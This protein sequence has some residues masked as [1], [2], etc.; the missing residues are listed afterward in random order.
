MLPQ[1][2]ETAKYE[3]QRQQ[4]TGYDVLTHNIIQSLRVL[5]S[6]QKRQNVAFPVL[7]VQSDNLSI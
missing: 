5:C 7:T 1:H 3:D 6:Y 2:A 4:A